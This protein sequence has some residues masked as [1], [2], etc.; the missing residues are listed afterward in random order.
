MNRNKKRI[1][2]G[3][4]IGAATAGIVAGS[5]FGVKQWQSGQ[6]DNKIIVSKDEQKE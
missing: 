6:W 5:I 1:I 2:A 4:A 3:A